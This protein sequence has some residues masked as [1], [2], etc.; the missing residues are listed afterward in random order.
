MEKYVI[1]ESK[2]IGIKPLFIGWEKCDKGHSFGPYVRDCYLIHFCLGGKGVLEN[3]EG[4]FDIGRGDFFVIRPG[5]VTTYTADNSDPWEYA[6]IAFSSEGKR[7]FESKGSVFETPERLD[8]KL[9]H[10]VKSSNRSA[11]GCLAV[12][13]DLLYRTFDSEEKEAEESV[14]RQIRRYIKYNYMLP[15]TVSGLARDFGFERSYLYRIFKA[16]YGIGIKDY[17]TSVRLRM[18]EKFLK[19]GYSVGESARM[20]G[21]DDRFNFSKAYKAHFGMSPSEV[22]KNK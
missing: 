6:W 19:D 7:Y 11:E 8:E 10:L 1:D 14:I 3:S 12:I 4:I 18:G 13:Y 16:R 9:L 20:S 2:D 15:I 22:I 5:E 17:I 21:Y